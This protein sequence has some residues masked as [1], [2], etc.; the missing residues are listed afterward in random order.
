MRIIQERL[1]CIGC[2]SC[3]AVCPN[4]YEMAEDG[5][6]TLKGSAVDETGNFVL[7]TDE[8]GCHREAAEICPVQI[9]SVVE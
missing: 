6:A 2:G 7:E 9:I 8:A 4:S 5:L 3:A 1:K